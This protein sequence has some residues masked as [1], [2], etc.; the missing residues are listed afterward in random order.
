MRKFLFGL[1]LFLYLI[2]LALF[3]VYTSNNVHE[4]VVVSR[5][6]AVGGTCS[7]IL[8]ACQDVTDAFI[9]IDWLLEMLSHWD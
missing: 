6:F 4:L 8:S 9:M 5:Y 1:S 2:A 3:C 7:L